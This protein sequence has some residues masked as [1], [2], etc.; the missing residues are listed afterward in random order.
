MHDRIDR[1]APLQHV[2]QTHA[3]E[4]RQLRARDGWRVSIDRYSSGIAAIAAF[5]LSSSSFACSASLGS[6]EFA[7]RYASAALAKSAC[8]S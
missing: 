1:A 5:S 7:V 3:E 6:S 8:A 2:I 4:R